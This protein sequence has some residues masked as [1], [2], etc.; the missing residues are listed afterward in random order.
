RPATRI[1]SGNRSSVARRCQSRGPRRSGCR[2]AGRVPTNLA[3]GAGVI[4]KTVE[5]QGVRCFAQPVR[6]E[7]AKDGFNIIAGPNGSGKS[8]LLE[9]VRRGLLDV[10]TATGAADLSSWVP[11]GPPRIVLEFEHGGTNYRLTKQFVSK[12]MARLERK[13]GRIWV[14]DA[15]GR[16]ADDTV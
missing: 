10:H 12:R 2:S 1:S 6:V 9:G 4:I 15:E 13:E 11:E 5:I 3:G 14:A 8:T 16:Q 7:L